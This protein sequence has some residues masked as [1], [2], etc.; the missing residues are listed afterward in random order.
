MVNALLL[1]S[2]NVMQDGLENSAIKVSTQR[3]R[4]NYAIFVAICTS[5]CVQG[6]CISPD[7]CQCNT[8]WT[9]STCDSRMQTL[10][11]IICSNSTHF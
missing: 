5:P 1:I 2:V 8:G 4:F 10:Y 3:E 9:G 6:T 7:M 11:L